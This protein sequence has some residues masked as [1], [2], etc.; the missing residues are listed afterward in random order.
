MADLVSAGLTESSNVGPAAHEFLQVF[1]FA[2]SDGDPQ[3]ISC[4]RFKVAKKA[5]GA[6]G[7]PQ[8]QAARPAGYRP[9]RLPV[10][11]T[12]AE[13]SQ[14]LCSQDVSQLREGV[15]VHNSPQTKNLPRLGALCG[16][17]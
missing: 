12:H 10:A 8:Y 1:G 14:G 16:T 11:P 15:S 4:H 6:P 17:V 7:G 3:R 2:I 9:G 5:T 13:P